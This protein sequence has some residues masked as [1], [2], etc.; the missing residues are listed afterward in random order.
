M[1][2]TKSWPRVIAIAIFTAAATPLSALA[3]VSGSATYASQQNGSTYDYNLLLN[4]TGDTALRTFWFS[5][6]PGDSFLP[7][8]P[9]SAAAPAGWT[10]QVVQDYYGTSIL[11]N[12]TGP[13][14]A[15]HTSLAGFEFT[16]AD[17]PDVL[18]GYDGYFGY[19]RVTTSYVYAST[20]NANDYPFPSQVGVFLAAPGPVPEPASAG[21]LA[22]AASVMA[23][24]RRRGK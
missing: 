14:L 2:R 11:W 23:L 3:A 10:A 24:R 15:P 5:W 6:M 13:G 19:Y 18:Q 16:S 21:L 8:V 22:G 7:S 9:D 4:N 17:S 20:V 1:N 12:T